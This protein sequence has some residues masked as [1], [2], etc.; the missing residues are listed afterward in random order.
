VVK[1]RKLDPAVLNKVQFGDDEDEDASDDDE[2]EDGDTAM[3]TGLDADDSDS[4][5]TT[6][7]A[8]AF[9]APSVKFI[10]DR[11]IDIN[12][13]ALLDMISVEG[14]SGVVTGVATTSSS[15]SEPPAKRRKVS[16]I[17]WDLI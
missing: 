2:E 1:F 4:K 15:T 8:S 11:D 10:I 16:D 14:V 3:D 9:A 17:R 13:T 12:S 7:A 5:T 6:T